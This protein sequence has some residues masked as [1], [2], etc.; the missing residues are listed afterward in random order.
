MKKTNVI[1]WLVPIISVVVIL[2]II[3]LGFRAFEVLPRPDWFQRQPIL[4]PSNHPLFSQLCLKGKKVIPHENIYYEQ[5][6]YKIRDYFY[7]LEKPD[8]TFRIV[9]TGDSFAW[10]WGVHDSR[11]TMFKRLECWFSL[12]NREKSIAVI[13]AAQ[14][15]LATPE[16]EKAL[17][18]F[19]FRLQP[20]LVLLIYNL[21]DG[22]SFHGMVPF[23]AWAE[24]R[25]QKRENI[26]HKISKLYKFID[27]RL[28]R[29]QVHKSTVNT[30]HQS[31]LGKGKDILQWKNSKKSLLRIK[32]KCQTH[33]SKLLVVLFPL[34]VDFEKETYL[35]EKEMKVI[36]NFLEKNKFQYLNLL[37]AFK[38]IK[39]ESLWC[40]P[41]DSHPNER[42]HQIA[43]ETIYQYL[44]NHQML[45]EKRMD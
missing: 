20:D 33:N 17:D 9:G 8:N 38:G 43:A 35:F 12:E 13:N 39:S 6:N 25:V 40:L 27:L 36:E 29:I 21:N 10:G 1:K 14:P 11:Y 45:P 3:E 2:L 5:Y 32:E 41:T 23:G 15:G 7:P 19:G 37:P 42:G 28:T 31:Y 26:W 22:A 44:V 4:A 30:Y 24:Q 18:E 34:L 16:E